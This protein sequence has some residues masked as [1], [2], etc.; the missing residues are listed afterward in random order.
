MNKKAVDEYRENLFSRVEELTIINAKQKSDI[1]HI[2]E[3]VDEIKAMIK[4]QNGRVRA[5]EKAI[6][7]M[8][9]VGSMVSL[10]FASIIGILFK[11]GV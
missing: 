2:K 10:I 6:S 5:N 11:R 7:A 3:S 4:E 1:T 8:R 9:A